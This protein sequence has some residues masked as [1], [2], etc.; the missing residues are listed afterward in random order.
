M[1]VRGTSDNDVIVLTDSTTQVNSPADRDTCT[2]VEAVYAN[3]DAGDD[4]LDASG[5]SCLSTSLIGGAGDDD[6][7]GSPAADT[8]SGDDWFGEGR[9]R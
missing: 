8:L 1:L 6:L 4:F 9:G 2:G 3:G 7:I 5:L